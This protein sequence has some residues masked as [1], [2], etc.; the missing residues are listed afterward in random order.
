MPSK[1]FWMN[2]SGELRLLLMDKEWWSKKLVFQ[3]EL[4]SRS[5]TQELLLELDN[6]I[7]SL[8]EIIDGRCLGDFSDLDPYSSY[9]SIQ[10]FG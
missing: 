2:L 10:I 6:R 4:E 8:S 9:H 1:E 7:F 5:S 3:P